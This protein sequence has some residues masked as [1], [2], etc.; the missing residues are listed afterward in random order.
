MKRHFCELMG[1]YIS[2]AVGLYLEDSEIIRE[3]GVLREN[4]IFI[5][6]YV[7][8]EIRVCVSGFS[9]QCAPAQRGASLCRASGKHLAHFL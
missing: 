8:A 3:I 5:G 1:I 9:S 4:K 7:R 2:T 6:H